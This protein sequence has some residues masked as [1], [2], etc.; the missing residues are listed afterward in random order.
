MLSHHLGLLLGKVSQD[1]DSFN[2]NSVWQKSTSIAKARQELHDRLDAGRMASITQSFKSSNEH[3]KV[4]VH[5]S[6]VE[7]LT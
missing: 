5:D 4:T 3:L 1:Q 2:K 6:L 7:S